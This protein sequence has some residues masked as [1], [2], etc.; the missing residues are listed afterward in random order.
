MKTLHL[1]FDFKNAALKLS[2]NAGVIFFVVF[3]ILVILEAFEINTSLKMTI[4]F[5]QPDAPI[6]SP[7]K[8]VRIN[9]EEY[10]K[11]VNRI[12]AAKTFQPSGGI[13]TNPFQLKN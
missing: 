1:N 12:Q 6:S 5:K 3:V 4:L 2:K 11:A 8:G 13:D 10:N 7:K 9:F